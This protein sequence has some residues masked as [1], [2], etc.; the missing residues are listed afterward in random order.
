MLDF[1]FDFDKK[2]SIFLHVGTGKS[3]QAAG[4][5]NDENTFLEKITYVFWGHALCKKKRGG[6]IHFLK[7]FFDFDKKIEKKN[8]ATKGRN[9]EMREQRNE[10]TMERRQGGKHYGP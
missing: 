4:G 9:D 3:F 2:N 7:E 6:V 10:G 1:F 8:W 5:R